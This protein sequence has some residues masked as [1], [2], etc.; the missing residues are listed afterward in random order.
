MPMKS[1]LSL[2]RASFADYHQI[3]ALEE[4]NGLREKPLEQWLHIWQNNPAWQ[5]LPDWPIGWV[6]EDDAGRVPVCSP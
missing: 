3:A 6:L 1:P 5:A 4:A 2:R